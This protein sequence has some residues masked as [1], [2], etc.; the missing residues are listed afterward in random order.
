M[1][2]RLKSLYEKEIVNKMMDTFSYRNKMEVPKLEKV[3]INM[4]L[5]RL[6]DAGR[7]S[8]VIEDAVNELAL[9]T[10]Q[11]PVVTKAR[12]SIAGFKLRE[13]APIGCMVTLRG[14]RMYE[15]LD[16]LFNLALPRVRDFR[17]VS[18]RG[19]DKRGNYT[20][21]IKEHIIFPEIDY[22]KVKNIKG[23]NIS[24]VT[25]AETDEEAKELLSQLGMPFANN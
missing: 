16:R 17:G 21:G 12:K 1:E 20:L 9:I 25:T 3:V 6:A 5:G 13:G 7:N 22:S 15:F 4:G 2:P 18:L 19:F 8:A 23:M 14:A 10:G 11:R 24:I